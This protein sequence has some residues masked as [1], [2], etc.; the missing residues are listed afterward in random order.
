VG[1]VSYL[2]MTYYSKYYLQALAFGLITSVLAGYIPAVK[3]SKV[4]PVKIIR[5]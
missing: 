3:A 1:N 5:G 2:P 4:D